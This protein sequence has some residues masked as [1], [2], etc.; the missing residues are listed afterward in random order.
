MV[1]EIAPS[2]PQPVLVQYGNNK[3][4]CEI[5][6]VVDFLNME[7]FEKHVRESSLLIFHAGAGSIINAIRS[8]KVPVVMPR[9]KMFGEHINDHQFELARALEVTGKIVVAYEANELREAVRT[10]QTLPEVVTEM[11]FSNQMLAQVKGTL[12]RYA[13]RYL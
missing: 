4:S 8:G 7:S 5:C 6:Q 3:F 12:E 9:R 13:E 2:L 11:S 10:A 1:V